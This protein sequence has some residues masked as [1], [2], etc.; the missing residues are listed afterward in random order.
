MLRMHDAQTRGI[1]PGKLN[2]NAGQGPVSINSDPAAGA[3][4]LG[5]NLWGHQGTLMLV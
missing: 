4:V 3:T 2:K 5:G 1:V